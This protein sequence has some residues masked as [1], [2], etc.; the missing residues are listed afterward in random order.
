M[1]LSATVEGKTGIQTIDV[2]PLFVTL[3]RTG[4]Q[5]YALR[6]GQSCTITAVLRYGIPNTPLNG[7]FPIAITANNPDAAT[8]TQSGPNTAVATGVSP[9][10]MTYLMRFVTPSDLVISGGGSVTVLAAPH[11]A[12]PGRAAARVPHRAHRA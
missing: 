4:A 6:V 8:L 3:P 5:C 10:E 9:G 12:A 2:L 1:T 11:G 7:A